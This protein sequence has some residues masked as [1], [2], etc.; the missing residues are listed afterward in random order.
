M[1]SANFFKPLILS[2]LAFFFVQPICAQNSWTFPDFSATQVFPSSKADL[3][4]K[5]HRS[6]SSV[7]VERGPA[8]STLYVTDDRK[9]YNLTKYPDQ[10][11]QCVSMKPEQAKM[12]PSPLELIQGK[13]LKRTSGGTEVFE[14]HTTKIE[15]V[16]VARPDGKTIESKVWEAEDLQGVPLKIESHLEDVTLRAVYRDVVLGTPDKA[17]FT[18]PDRCTPFEKMWQVA[19]VRNPK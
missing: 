4:M 7:M 13:I 17:R 14:G 1:H 16:V 19:E 9:V 18:V 11:H 6:G 12:L 3:T 5:V 10:S 15:S 2:F 8:I